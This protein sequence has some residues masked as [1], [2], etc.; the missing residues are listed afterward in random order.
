[1]K[2]KKL[3]LYG[4]KSFADRTVFEFEDSLSALVG[5]N[6]SGKS[7]VADAI[8]WVLGERS[9]HKLRGTEMA[10]I[11]FNGSKNRK[12][13][14]YAE[15][16]LT[17]DNA[18][19]WLP[20]EYEEV[21]IRRRVDRT[22]QSDYFL[23]AEQCRLKDIHSLIM[24][25]GVGTS[26]YSFIEQGQIDH[27]LRAGAKERREVFE[28]AAG[29]NRF[30]DQKRT[31]E[32]KLE[33]VTANLARVSDIVQEV[34]HQLRS[35][36]YQAG[37]ARTFKR[38]TR[39]LER[40]RLAHS[41]HQHRSLQ[42]ERRG[43]AE[44]LE[45]A[46]AEKAELD[47]AA[48]EAEQ[49]LETAR[50]RLQT[51]QNE[52]SECRQELT[53]A[54]ARLESLQREEEINRKRRAELEEQLGEI[55][56]RRK[57]LRERLEEMGAEADDVEERLEAI[58]DELENR[59]EELKSRRERAAVARSRL[60]QARQEVEDAKEGVFDLLER[61]S[62]LKNQLDVIET[63]RRTLRSRLER[64]RN[65]RNELQTRLDGARQDR[66]GTR[67]EYGS[68]QAEQETLSARL[69]EVK[70]D[71]ADVRTELEQLGEREVR[72]KS[73]RSGK[74]G[75]RDVLQDMESRAE[76][77]RSGVKRLMEAE[78]EGLLG[79]VARLLDAPLEVAG[80]VDAALGERA[81]ALA[82]RTA[83]AAREAMRMLADGKG[84]AEL[85]VLDRLQP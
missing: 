76:G 53:R 59:S 14:N 55:H 60:Q 66:D 52:L 75:R 36:K 4:F 27:L 41:V 48:R 30:L 5:P 44:R 71:L 11:I 42:A 38:Q 51:A 50:S 12:P 46:A 6:G 85:L 57:T 8:K 62:R 45:E 13:L 47:E 10:N 82:F 72:I 24:D 21:S 64:I 25:T 35:V 31:A 67:E 56:R 54:E 84:R 74:A 79:P 19:G 2:L 68:V 18:D 28:E 22:G 58:T 65:R 61:E 80:A 39:E 29:I 73:E 83:A 37:R 40:L 9:A 7:N 33:R 78:P 77:I 17:I 26:C 63:E 69:A 20:V 3:E 15:V 16:T 70:S 43:I 34:E 81:Q 49:K 1:M 32:R 23:N